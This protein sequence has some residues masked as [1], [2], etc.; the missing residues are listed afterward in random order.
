VSEPRVCQPCPHFSGYYN[1]FQYSDV[2]C[3]WCRLAASDARIAQLEADLRSVNERRV[4]A[5]AIL[6]AHKDYHCTCG[7]YSGSSVET[8]AEYCRKCGARTDDYPIGAYHKC[9]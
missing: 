2:T 4:R 8:E 5:E 9:S 7:F 3:P 6:A 1:G